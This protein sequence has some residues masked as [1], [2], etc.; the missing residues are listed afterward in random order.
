MAARLC[1]PLMLLLVEGCSAH[2]ASLVS[3]A[4]VS[5]DMSG[6]TRGRQPPGVSHGRWFM[7]TGSLGEESVPQVRVSLRLD[8]HDAAGG[9]GHELFRDGAVV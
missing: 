5:F 9:P 1:P 6:G 7:G 8:H 2:G 4:G 3:P